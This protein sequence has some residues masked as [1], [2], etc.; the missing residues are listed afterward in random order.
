MDITF[1]CEKCGQQV[2]IDEAGAG[3][4]VQCPGCGQLLIVPSPEPRQREPVA[5][6]RCSFCG[7]TIKE[8]ANVCR[9]CGRPLTESAPASPVLEP[10]AARPRSRLIEAV[11]IGIGI[12]L[13]L[14]LVAV[15]AAS[16]TSWWQKRRVVAQAR[17]GLVAALGGHRDTVSGCDQIAAIWARKGTLTKVEVYRMATTMAAAKDKLFRKRLS[18]FM[19]YG[20]PS[21]EELMKEEDKA[22]GPVQFCDELQWRCESASNKQHGLPPPPRRKS[23]VPPPATAVDSD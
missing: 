15:F 10:I 19:L 12:L 14:A 7:E 11:K 6:G 20:S 4:Q 17:A 5:T 18:D 23:L 8:G 22:L 1:A 2:A 13:L 9:F 16:R 3:I 21:P